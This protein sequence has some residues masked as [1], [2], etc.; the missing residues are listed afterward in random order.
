VIRLVAL[1]QDTQAQ[2][3]LDLEGTPSISLNLAV[4]KPG[5]TMQRHAPYS[6]TFR[7]PFTD[8]NNVFFAHFYEVTLTDGDFDPTQKT[9]VIIFEDGVQVIRG[10]MQLRAVRLMAQVYEVNVLGDVADLFAEMGSKLLQAAF[11]DG[12]DYTTDYN[13]NNTA[14]NVINSQDLNQSISIGDQVPDG[15]IIIPY[16]DHGLTTNQQPLAAEY[17]FGLRNPDSS[18]NGLYAEML[19][20]AIKLRVLVDLIIRTNGFTYS[21][22]FFASDLF[23]SLYMTLATESERIPAEAA[24]Q[25]LASKNTNQSNFT[26]FQWS[27]VSFPDTAVLGFDN[28]SNYNT[29]TSTYIAAQGGIHRFHV[30]MRVKASFGATGTEFLVIGRISKGGTSL[31]SQTV[32]MVEGSSPVFVSDDLRTIEFQVET[33]LSASD[34]VQVQVWFPLLQTG[35]SIE[36]LGNTL[37]ADPTPIFFKCTYAP[38]GQVN[39][40]QALPRIKQKDL[41]RDLCQRFNLVIEASPDNPKQLVI[42]P[43]DD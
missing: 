13:Y 27:T 37:G 21:S 19:K 41:M 9:E 15:T 30:K 7:L 6:Q 23:G 17:D 25:F 20:P 2:S 10:A 39:I 14:A 1:D 16:A 35:N 22:D 38:G 34:G 8:R 32:T 29:T 24:G 43:Y 18:I 31:G 3:T 42:E 33:L 40:P 4:A 26:A 5:E 28:D 11:L 12:N 36:V